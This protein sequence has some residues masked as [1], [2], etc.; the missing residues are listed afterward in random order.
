MATDKIPDIVPLCIGP[1]R[2]VVKPKEGISD[3]VGVQALD[4]RRT[5]KK[6]LIFVQATQLIQKVLVELKKKGLI[7]IRMRMKSSELKDS[8][9]IGTEGLV[10]EPSLLSFKIVF[11]F[12]P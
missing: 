8:G 5:C 3:Q 1:G 11:Q 9:H 10:W 7:R 12:I 4:L 6:F 2:L